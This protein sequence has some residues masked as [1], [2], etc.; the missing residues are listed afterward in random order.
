VRW[1]P[2]VRFGVG[3]VLMLVVGGARAG[4]DPPFVLT[5]EA[6][7]GSCP[8]DAVLRADVARH[9]YDESRAAGVRLNLAIEVDGPDYLGVLVAFDK[10]GTE[11]SRRIRGK[12]CFDVAHALAFL[13]GLVIELGGHIEP[14]ASPAPPR[15]PSPAPTAAPVAAPSRA[16]DV[17]AVLL[18]GAQGGFGPPV[19]ATGEAGVEIATRSG[20]L[21]PSVRLSGFAGDAYLEGGGSSATLWFVGGR[22]ELCPWRFG[23]AKVV[24]RPC[25]GGELGRVQAHGQIAV[26][27]RTAIELWASAEATLRVQW[28]ATRSFFVEL[29]GGPEF[30][31]VRTRYYFEPDRT[32]YVVPSVTARGATGLGLQF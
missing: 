4:G 18:A 30:P 5:Y 25:A 11:S 6:P 16:I 12:T 26:E 20:I 7:L 29:G 8:A 32:A 27:P 23:S 10:S 1:L 2:R 19:R 3:L 22:L 9:V 14:D 13:A 17:S 24:V 21:A 15:P 31:L 28:W